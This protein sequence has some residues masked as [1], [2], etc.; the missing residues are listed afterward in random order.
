[1]EVSHDQHKD[2]HVMTRISTEQILR[3]AYLQPFTDFATVKTIFWV[4]FVLSVALPFAIAPLPN[5]PPLSIIG[6]II[7]LY[8]ILLTASVLVRWHRHLILL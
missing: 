8:P 5:D 6:L 2:I 3:Q 7:A 4:P 1:M